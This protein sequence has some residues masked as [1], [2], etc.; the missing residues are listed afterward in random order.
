MREGKK[1]PGAKI[2]HGRW[3]SSDSTSASHRLMLFDD[4]DD[5]PLFVLERNA[6][7][8]RL[9]ATNAARRVLMKSPVK[10]T[11]VESV[12]LI[13]DETTFTGV[14]DGNVHFMPSWVDCRDGQSVVVDGKLGPGPY[15]TDSAFVMRGRYHHEF[16]RSLPMP[17]DWGLP[18]PSKTVMR[19]RHSFQA[20]QLIGRRVRQACGSR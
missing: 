8:M 5:A 13:D 1:G 14:W 6:D 9:V 16:A 2:F 18:T 20:E 12:D 3:T 7:A 17:P 11:R 15:T 19:L 4:A 10:I